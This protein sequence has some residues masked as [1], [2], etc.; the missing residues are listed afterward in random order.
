MLAEVTQD[1]KLLENEWVCLCAWL[2]IKKKVEMI[3][4]VNVLTDINKTNE[5]TL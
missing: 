3:I 5:N 4:H 1:V 2:N